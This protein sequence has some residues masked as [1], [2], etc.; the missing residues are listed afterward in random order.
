MPAPLPLSLSY[1]LRRRG[2]YTVRVLSLLTP[3]SEVELPPLFPRPRPVP[4]I[5]RPCAPPLDFSAPEETI[6]IAASLAT[7]STP[8]LAKLSPPVATRLIE[9]FRAQPPLSLSLLLDWFVR[10]VYPALPSH[11]CCW[12]GEQF[13]KIPLLSTYSG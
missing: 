11:E 2:P 5:S 1:T 12:P 13:R 7:L 9:Q 3:L 4:T 6:E 10:V 8:F